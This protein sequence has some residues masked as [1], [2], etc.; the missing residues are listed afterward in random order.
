MYARQMLEQLYRRFPV[1]QSFGERFLP[2]LERVVNAAP[3]VRER[4]LLLV[5]TS[6]QKEVERRRDDTQKHAQVDDKLL[7]AVA[8]VLHHWHPP[9]WMLNWNGGARPQS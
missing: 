8:G 2:L 1:S 9:D 6:F 4:I 3:D 7:V 5:E